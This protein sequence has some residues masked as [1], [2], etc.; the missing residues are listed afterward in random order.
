VTQTITNF[1]FVD[2]LISVSLETHSVEFTLIPNAPPN[3]IHLIAEAIRDSG[4]D[5]PLDTTK[6]LF[7]QSSSPVLESSDH[8]LPLE[9]NLDEDE[10]VLSIKK[11]SS[12][13]SKRQRKPSL[14]IPSNGP[15][16][17]NPTQIDQCVLSIQGMT[18]SACV[19]S[20]EKI[21]QGLPGVIQIKVSL[22]QETAYVDYNPSQVTPQSLIDHISNTGFD[23]T[24]IS[25]SPGAVALDL[26]SG[27]K[28]PST[29]KIELDIY[30]MTCTVCSSTIEREVGKLEGVL[31][32]QISL[33]TKR[34]V[35]LVQEHTLGI[36]SIIERIE[37]L[38]F[39]ALVPDKNLQV[40]IN[41]L[42]RTKEIIDWK[43]SLKYCCYFAIPNFVLSMIL[44]MFWTTQ[45]D[46]MHSKFV[47]DTWF[48]MTGLTLNHF[49]QFVL[50]CPIQFTV[51]LRFLRSAWYSLL[52]GSATMDTLVAL[53][54][55]SAFVASI[56]SL[57]YSMIH[58]LHPHAT[59]FFDTC[60]TLITFICLGKYLE[61]SAKAKTSSAL[62]KL[63][64]LQPSNAT[65]MPDYDPTTPGKV[66]QETEI[67]TELIQVQ[68]Y[69]KV[70]PGDR[71]PADGLVVHGTST[72]DESMV[73]GEPIPVTK[74]PGL[75]VIAGTVN[76]SGC[77]IIHATHVGSDTA[78]ARIVALVEQAQASKAPIQRWADKIAGIF[79]PIVVLLALITLI[80]WAT[81]TKILGA[82][83]FKNHMQM[84]KDDIF[85]CLQL[86]ISVIVVA[87]PCTLGLSV[88]TAVMVGTGVGAQLGI[89][90]KG[91][92]S[93]ERVHQLDHLVFDKTGTL[94]EGKMKVSECDIYVMP[95]AVSPTKRKPSKVSRNELRLTEHDFWLLV[96]AVESHSEHPLAKAIVEHA[97]G[98]VQGNEIV[99][100]I[101]IDEFD[102]IPGL[103]VQCQASF[104]DGRLFDVAIGS[105]SFL[106]SLGIALE[107]HSLEQL[108]QRRD[109]LMT[110][111]YTVVLVAI[112]N[113]LAGLIALGDRL[114]PN[115]FEVIRCLQED[116]GISVS[117]VTGDNPATALVFA[118]Q[119][120]IP[121]ENVFGSVSPS[122]KS[123]IVRA[124][125]AQDYDALSNFVNAVQATQ[126]VDA[127][128]TL[129]GAE[130]DQITEAKLIKLRSPVVATS[131]DHVRK[132]SQAVSSTIRRPFTKLRS[133]QYSSLFSLN[134]SNGQLSHSSSEENFEEV[135]TPHTELHLGIP[136][137][138]VSRNRTKVVAMI[139]DGINDSP[140]LAAADIG[141]AL[142]TGT[143]VAM[144]A[145]DVVILNNSLLDLIVAVDLSRT[146]FRR[147]QL[148][149]FWAGIYNIV[150]IPLA[151]G[152]GLPWGIM[153]HPMAAGAAM[154][155]SSVSVVLSS[156]MLTRYRPPAWVRSKPAQEL[157]NHQIEMIH[158]PNDY[159]HLEL[160]DTQVRL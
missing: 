20:I 27:Q 128:S 15:K 22:M 50:T 45:G 87:C 116:M 80:V 109:Q 4:F 102:M 148:N 144:E 28:Q 133:G 35:I 101:S 157:S 57:L 132:V 69:L 137:P 67:A 76:G 39:D 108:D 37:D 89:L 153:L 19:A 61:N 90:I 70:L 98:V 152:M 125:Q 85:C 34:A 156:L 142:G 72:V 17:T 138:P 75:T 32:I 62:T 79:V 41:N 145:A 149:F 7:F 96:G 104:S 60:T 99:T 123:E 66:T 5:V 14:G 95:P 113:Q 81:A 83:P 93:L 9:F 64:S 36:R 115:A 97:K 8:I 71:M 141:I 107:T 86:C 92:E 131:L 10:N 16:S 49:I 63:L 158:I 40:Q 154:A 53:G 120:G 65:L 127:V 11:R 44:P 91:G 52:H 110:K 68:D 147:I 77:L 48:I 111:G 159:D 150:A 73:T 54:T 12:L 100:S 25:V 122:G 33:A 84:D 51:G 18:C 118:R 2:H 134:S 155:L 139:G 47:L 88:P 135:A 24:L 121:D 30:G 136:I 29:T 31:S 114:K 106:R 160:M 143:D 58:P 129:E 23:A 56:V 119:C 13:E 151:M 42:Q 6:T 82:F 103:G 126:L 146:I 38:G 74:K 105:I 3:A 94:T 78:L 1:E 112:S 117:M 124:L 26:S 55:F 46:G 43:N 140:A 130:M 59:V 21:I